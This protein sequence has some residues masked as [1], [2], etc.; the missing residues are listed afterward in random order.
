VFQKVEKVGAVSVQTSKRAR[1]LVPA[2]RRPNASTDSDQPTEF[3]IVVRLRNLA[4]RTPEIEDEL[5]C[6]YIAQGECIMGAADAIRAVGGIVAWLG[7]H[8]LK[9]GINGKSHTIADN[10][11]LLARAGYAECKKAIAW[12]SE[13]RDR[14]NSNRLSGLGFFVMALRAYR[15]R[16]HLP[17]VARP[18]RPQKRD[19]EKVLVAKLARQT[20]LLHRAIGDLEKACADGG[21]NPRVLNAIRAEMDRASFGEA[22]ADALDDVASSN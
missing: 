12:T 2:A 15:N 21:W 17:P 16:D 11:V 20:D 6:N 19:R 9:L 8:Q 18:K 4:D 22:T 3:E 7:G 13:N 1:E 10:A 5:L 14:I